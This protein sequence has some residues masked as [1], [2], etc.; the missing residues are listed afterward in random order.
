MRSQKSI[1]KKGQGIVEYVLVTA[2]ISLAAITLFRTF[3]ADI[4]KAYEKAGEA[5]VE[6]VEQD[7]MTNPLGRE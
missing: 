6:S 5:L 1:F 3:R 2:L 4:Q 7:L